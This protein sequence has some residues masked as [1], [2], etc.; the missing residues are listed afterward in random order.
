MGMVY[1]QRRYEEKVNHPIYGL[2]TD[3][4]EFDFLMISG[5]GNSQLEMHHSGHT[6]EIVETLA[7][8]HTQAS[9][10]SCSSPGGIPENG[11]ESQVALDNQEAL[12]AHS[13]GT[14]DKPLSSFQVKTEIESTDEDEEVGEVEEDKDDDYW[15]LGLFLASGQP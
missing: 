3:N 1:T 13:K 14:S 11:S 2:S 7:Y 9:I 4:D 6:Q 15:G 8:F 12:A 10:L 5:E